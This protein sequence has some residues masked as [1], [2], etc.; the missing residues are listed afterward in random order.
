[1]RVARRENF[2]QREDRRLEKLLEQTVERGSGRHGLAADP[3]GARLERE[4]REIHAAPRRSLRRRL[5]A[6]SARRG[7]G[8]KS[9]RAAEHLVVHDD[10][11]NGVPPA[12]RVEQVAE[13]GPRRLAVPEEREHASSGPRE[14]EPESIRQR[15]SLRHEMRLALGLGGQG[16]GAAARRDE[17]AWLASK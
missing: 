10:R 1:G 15:A 7:A 6:P 17:E 9:T 16:R 5:G 11:A 2:E 4:T 13:S 12:R 14:R 8:R 3:R